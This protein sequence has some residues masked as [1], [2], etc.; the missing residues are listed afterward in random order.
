MNMERHGQGA[1]FIRR[2]QIKAP[3]PARFQ[4][5]DRFMV[6]RYSGKRP[7]AGVRVDAVYHVLWIAPSFNELYSH[8]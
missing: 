7:M 3:I 2:T 5:R 1:E 4:D 8:S 6:F